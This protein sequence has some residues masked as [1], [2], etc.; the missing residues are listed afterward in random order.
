MRHL[1]PMSVLALTA[2]LFSASGA[3]VSDA[4]QPAE[5]QP[6]LASSDSLERLYLRGRT[7]AAFL[8]VAKSR[9]ET[10]LANYA[11]AA[12]S[13]EWLSRARAVPG[14]WR[15]LVVAEDWCGDSANTIPYLAQLS[16]SVPS[17]ELRIVNARD[18]RWV[19]ESHRTPDSRAATPTVV[20]LD[21]TGSEAGCF[22][23]RPAALRQWLVAN[24]PRLSEAGVR[25]SRDEWRRKDAGQSTVREMVELL[26]SA[27]AGRPRC[28]PTR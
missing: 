4:D 22:V 1:P 18:G 17:L 10:W 25:R 27:A 9:R 16:D 5:K 28:G 3:C 21:S 19:M 23:E 6:A 14:R 2:L 7:F 11:S 15:L 26:E 20:L 12:R 24:R 13:D 8:A